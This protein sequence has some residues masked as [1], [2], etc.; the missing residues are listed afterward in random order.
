MTDKERGVLFITIAVV[1]GLA[2]ALVLIKLDY[3][4]KGEQRQLENDNHKPMHDYRIVRINR[5]EYIEVD[6][7]A[8][9]NRVY[10]LTHKGDCDNHTPIGQ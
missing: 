8:G 9:R 7:G 10:S 4:P 2:L 3:T 5:C 6:N 1:L